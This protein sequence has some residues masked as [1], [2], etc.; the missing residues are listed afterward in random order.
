MF[1]FLYLGI[2][3][4]LYIA[5][6][7]LLLLLSFLPKYR[8]SIPARFF[9]W[10]N[11]PFTKRGIW[12][13]ACS[14]G[15]VKSLAPVIEALEN[16]T[17]ANL[18]VI[19]DTG[20]EAAGAYDV[21][22][23]FLPFEIFLPFWVTRQKVLVV[24][25]AEL[26]YM[27]FTAAKSK[28][29]KTILLNARIS[30]RSWPR[31][32]RFKWFYRKIFANIDILFAQSEKDAARVRE[33]GAKEVRVIGNIKRFASVET[34]RT[35]HKPAVEVVTLASTHAGEELLLLKHL[36]FDGRVVIVVP[37][38]PQRF[39]E[40]AS[41]IGAFCRER[42]LTFHRFSEREDFESDV[43]LMDRMGELV[44]LY[45]ISDIVLLGGS[46]VEGVGG[47]NPLE[48]AHFGVRLVSGPHIFNQE[49]LFPLVKGVVFSDAEDVETTIAEARAVT[50]EAQGGLATLMK[51]LEDVV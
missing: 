37:R 26:W 30:D 15:E 33:L 34:T 31:Y 3:W 51:E 50:T 47:H 22:R 14:L 38:H 41:E 25:E 4:L 42:G 20:Y 46:F 39:N 9:L 32:R 44:N 18:S 43:V 16:R 2:G 29:T 36:R 10:R 19:T 7:P 13:H 28:G 17:P 8:R 11:P 5:A 21:E 35:F 27:L 23:R 12:F 49:A 1:T 6:L 45:A 40:A 48:P 24:L